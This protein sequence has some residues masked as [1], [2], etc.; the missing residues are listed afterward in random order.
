MKGACHVTNWVTPQIVEEDRA[1]CDL[2]SPQSPIID[3]EL[4]VRLSNLQSNEECILARYR[5][6]HALIGT[7]A[8]KLCDCDFGP[9]ERTRDE[10]GCGV[11][12]ETSCQLATIGTVLG[13]PILSPVQPSEK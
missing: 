13:H 6:C 5:L 9:L 2:L 4:A 8:F 11:E 3:P 1:R 7:I 10:S 12:T